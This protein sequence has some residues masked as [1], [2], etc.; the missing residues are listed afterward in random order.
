[1]TFKVKYD[2][3][4]YGILAAFFLPLIIGLS[5]FFITSSDISF[6]DYIVKLYLANIMTHAISLCVF[7]NIIIFLVI[8]RFDMLKS[9]RGVLAMTIFWA[10][11]V[12]IVKFI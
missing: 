8:I 11:I 10:A 12:F 7:P 9:A 6:T 3:V 2:K 1:M 4:L 5:V